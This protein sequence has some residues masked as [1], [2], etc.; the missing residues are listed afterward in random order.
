M[1]AITDLIGLTNA[2][3]VRLVVVGVLLLIALAAVRVLFKLTK[4]AVQ[5]GCVLIVVVVG[6]IFFLTVLS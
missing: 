1:E 6:A 2:E 4:T 5:I 3:F